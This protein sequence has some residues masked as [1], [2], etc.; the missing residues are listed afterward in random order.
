MWRS[1]LVL[2]AVTVLTYSETPTPVAR[3][4]VNANFNYGKVGNVYYNSTSVIR[5]LLDTLLQDIYNRE[6]TMETNEVLAHHYLLEAMA[7]ENKTLEYLIEMRRRVANISVIGEA[8]SDAWRDANT[9]VIAAAENRKSAEDKLNNEIQTLPESDPRASDAL[10]IAVNGEPNCT[11]T[12][13]CQNCLVV[14]KSFIILMLDMYSS[15]C[16]NT[17]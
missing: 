12:Q 15:N 1:V 4:I 2:L 11:I 17:M 14:S 6:A 7:Y 5:T 3:Q 16:N 8:S 9:N 13:T 10:C